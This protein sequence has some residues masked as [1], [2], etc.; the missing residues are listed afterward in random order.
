MW[1]NLSTHRT[2]ILHIHAYILGPSILSP[3][4]VMP[5]GYNTSL[6]SKGSLGDWLCGSISPLYTRVALVI[7]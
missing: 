1:L 3:R 6:A 4:R 2:N 7:R 5:E